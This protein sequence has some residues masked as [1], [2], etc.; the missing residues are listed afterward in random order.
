MFDPTHGVVFDLSQG[1][2]RP[3]GA[4]RAVLVPAAALAKLTEFLDDEA[5]AA[6][7]RALGAAAGAQ[8]A[9][10][11]GGVERA[12]VA[13]LQE[14][15]DELAGR[16][17]LAGL[18]V[19]STET[20]GKTLVAVVENSPLQERALVAAMVEGLFQSATGRQVKALVVD[21]EGRALR[22]LVAAGPVI[23]KAQAAL[24]AG[25]SFGTLMRLVVGGSTS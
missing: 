3:Q 23:E 21:E 20:W 19:L 13:P 14:L 5:A 16:V 22:V 12:S 15:T 2:V 11:L 25:Q 18:G 24:K 6:L 17:A 9:T 8:V 1:A 10:A 4:D 7:G